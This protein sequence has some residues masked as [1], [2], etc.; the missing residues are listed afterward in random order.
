MKLS[1][2]YL[3]FLIAGGVGNEQGPKRKSGTD[4]TEE[5]V[6]LDVESL[7]NEGSALCH[8]PGL[9]MKTEFHDFYDID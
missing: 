6:S 9:E 5:V 8:M 3:D 4:F 1:I 2:I 7:D